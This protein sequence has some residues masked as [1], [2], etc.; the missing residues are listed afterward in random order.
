ML[1]Q[2]FSVAALCIAYTPLSCRYELQI[3]V[4]GRQRQVLKTPVRVPQRLPPFSWGLFMFKAAA[5]AAIIVSRLPIGVPLRF[6][7]GA[8]RGPS[9]ALS[10]PAW[11]LRSLRSLLSRR[12][13]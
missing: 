1:S 5:S 12:Q 7:V 13:L 10:R 3:V 4:N 11:V 2:N 9:R 6:T 8:S